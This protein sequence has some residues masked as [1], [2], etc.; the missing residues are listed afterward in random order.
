[1]E[2]TVY[3]TTGALTLKTKVYPFCGQYTSYR[4]DFW[5]L[6]QLMVTGYKVGPPSY[7]LVNKPLNYHIYGGPTSLITSYKVGPPEL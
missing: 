3:P 1:M 4:W 6:T 7:Q 5:L 2:C